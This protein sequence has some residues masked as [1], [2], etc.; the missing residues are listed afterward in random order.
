MGAVLLDQLLEF[1]LVGVEDWLELLEEVVDGEA[2]FADAADQVGELA[3]EEGERVVLQVGQQ[4]VD[5]VVDQEVGA[6]VAALGAD[7]GNADQKY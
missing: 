5:D 4:W 2:A 3:E 6:D 7:C 1:V